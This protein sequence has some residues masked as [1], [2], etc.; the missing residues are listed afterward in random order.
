MDPKCFVRIL[1]LAKTPG[2]GGHGTGYLLSRDRVLTAAHVVGEEKHTAVQYDLVDGSGL[3]QPCRAEV[4]WC[5]G[6]DCD[7]ALLKLEQPFPGKVIPSEMASLPLDTLTPWVTKGWA[8]ALGKG[9][10]V[11]D[12]MVGLKGD[13][14]PFLAT[15]E[16]V[17]LDV[18]PIPKS[19]GRLKG[20]SGAPVFDQRE[21]RRLLA[22]V[23]RA[24]E[25][26]LNGLQATPLTRA[27]EKPTF[28][29]ALGP[30]I[31]KE[32]PQALMQDFRD[33][34][35]KESGMVACRLAKKREGWR[36]FSEPGNGAGLA[37]EL[38][39]R[40]DAIE[41]LDLFNEL[42]KEMVKSRN[43]AEV[44][45][46]CHVESLLAL[47][48][49]LLLQ[50]ALSEGLPAL[51]GGALLQLPVRTVTLAEL[52]VAFFEG[53]PS[54]WRPR[55]GE[56]PDGVA[57]LATPLEAGIDANAE[58]LLQAYLEHLEGEFLA[59]EDRHILGL[60]RNRKDGG[61]G[62]A[63][64]EA[65][66]DASTKAFGLINDELEHE[67]KGPDG[68]LRRYFLF[69]PQFGRDHPDFVRELRNRLPSIH[70]I[71]LVSLERMDLRTERRVSR[72]IRDVVSRSAEPKDPPKG[73]EET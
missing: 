69:E 55:S 29:E 51:S 17:D 14:H 40:A 49:P 26:F 52:A 70:V 59:A 24:P 45:G 39:Y 48:A 67:T 64:A 43:E 18:S 8:G 38:L 71:E 15:A 9:E 54:R 41:V 4:V 30:E 56:H 36:R 35:A 37:D 3:E 50:R 66:A 1:P 44:R 6:K 53:R 34:L 47:A 2:I 28:L 58:L 42:H 72:P 61:S 65:M 25:S 68:S 62:E 11:Q 19:A 7:I 46:A 27:L 60:L 23:A 20:I 33:L 63:S 21:T 32:R 13:A 73:R 16:Y 57:R 5:G 12:S 10:R 22:V 31:I